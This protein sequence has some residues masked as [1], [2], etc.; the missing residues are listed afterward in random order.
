MKYYSSDSEV[1]PFREELKQTDEWK[2][3]NYDIEYKFNS[4][5][6]RTKEIEELEDDFILTFGCS[7]SEGVG[8]KQE[9]LWCEI[10]AKNL[11]IDLFNAA[12]QATGMDIVY[13]NGFM[14]T[15]SDAPLPK[16]VVAQWPH[17]ERKSF[18]DYS[19]LDNK[20]IPHPMVEDKSGYTDK[21]G[22][23]YTRRY[24][25]DEAEMHMNAL[26]WFDSFNLAWDRLGVPVL[27]FCWENDLPNYLQKSR[28]KAHFVPVEHVDRAKDGVHDGPDA[29]NSTAKV[30]MNIKNLGNFTHKV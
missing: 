21:D 29:H 25:V 3:D 12:K 10:L 23:W 8:L 6:Y 1:N 14:W 11:N 16:L 26:S 19:H 5:G 24:I 2:Y 4:L 20:A 30:L 7:Y 28:Y 9:D 27:N 22:W 18:F 13:W 15:N 17:K